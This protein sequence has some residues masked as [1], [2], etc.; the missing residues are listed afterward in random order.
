MG[1]RYFRGERIR[2]E[3]EYE[4]IREIVELLRPEFEREPVYVL[5]NVLVANRQLDC[6]LLTRSG[7]LIL[8]LKAFSGEIHG[9]ENGG[10]EVIT[11]DGPIPVPNLFT[12]AKTQRQD[13]IDRLIPIYRE[14]LPHISQNSLRKIG[15]WAYFSRGSTYPAGQIDLRRVKWFRV[16]TADTLLEAMR[17]PESGYSLRIQDM[18]A[19]VAGLHLQE[20]A[21]ETDQPV[22][23]PSPERQPLFRVSRRGVVAISLLTVVICVIAIIL[24]VPDVREAI[25]PG[26]HGMFLIVAGLLSEG[27][28]DLVKSGST[29]D[30]SR[31]GVMYLNRIR[32]AAGVAPVSFDDRA[33]GLAL[34]R[35]RDMAEFRYLDYTNPVTGS[36]AELVKTSYGIHPHEV[37]VENAY[38]QWSGY[39]LGIEHQAIDAW[40]SDHGNRARLL[41]NMSGGAIACTHG[42]CSFIGITPA[43]APGPAEPIIAGE[44]EPV[45]PP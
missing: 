41:S 11:N 15:A 33:Y 23:P 26:V 22:T 43:D 44:S 13:L 39:R 28:R 19:I 27:S 9:L 7:P 35:G 1:I 17:F 42:Y 34:W 30:D 2:Y 3:H 25:I 20:Y 8:E 16:V 18:D 21:F 40:V 14:H 29:T 37:L 24:L 38:G 10:W 12:Q 6:V 32:I 31:D 45:P 4:Q 36:S 5:T